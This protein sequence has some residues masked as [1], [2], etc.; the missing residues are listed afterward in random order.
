[1]ETDHDLA[2]DL[3]VDPD[4]PSPYRGQDYFFPHNS[5]NPKRLLNALPFPQPHAVLFS[6]SLKNLKLKKGPE[7]L[8][9]TSSRTGQTN[10][11]GWMCVWNTGK[12]LKILTGRNKQLYSVGVW[13]S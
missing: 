11:E 4:L 2:R 1:M 5:M 8:D 10:T 3:R 7:Q 9:W 6:A 13:I 12:D